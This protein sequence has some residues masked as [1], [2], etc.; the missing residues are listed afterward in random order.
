[1]SGDAAADDDAAPLTGPD[2]STRSLTGMYQFGEQRWGEL[3]AKKIEQMITILKSKG[4][5]VLWVGLPAVRGAKATSDTLFLN[6]L[7]RE[8]AGKA[9]ITYV[10]VWDGFADE[11]GH[12]VQSGPDFEGQIRRLRSYDGVY[13]TK[14]G[15]RKLAHFVEREITRLLAAHSPQIALPT[16][17][18]SPNTNAVTRPLAGHIVP[19][20]APSVG[21]DQLLGGPASRPLPVDALAARTLTKGEPLTPPAGRADD[22]VWPH[23]EVG[24]EQIKSE[25]PLA[26]A[27][28][29]ALR[30]VMARATPPGTRKLQHAKPR[31]P[32]DSGRAQV[33]AP[34]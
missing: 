32:M 21:T 14:A 20:E 10:D 18:A 24:Q 17:P 30:P 5:P 13:F 1:L 6:S 29:D 22:F 28:P 4:V 16:E 25:P 33:A 27:L 34:R 23:R 2:K 15:A 9:G 31:M 11:A 3:Y 7:Y 8:A 12:F 26:A 19:L